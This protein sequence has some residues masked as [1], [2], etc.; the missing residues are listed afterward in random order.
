VIARIYVFLLALTGVVVLIVAV[1]PWHHDPAAQTV[2]PP[3]VTYAA[4][5]A[6][7]AE[8]QALEAEI[9]KK[10]TALLTLEEQR[11]R[12]QHATR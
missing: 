6:K 4:L 10:L 1:A 5:L 9:D 8:T 2:E 3:P 11:A 7:L 12:D